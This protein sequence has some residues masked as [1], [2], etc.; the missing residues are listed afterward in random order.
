MNLQLAR[1]MVSLIDDK[2]GLDIML[3]NVGKATTLADYFI[4]ATGTSS[5]H[6]QALADHLEKSLRDENHFMKHKE[7]KATNGWLL[8][9]FKDIVVHLFNSETRAYY[10]L[11][12]IWSDAEIMTI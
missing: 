10:A 5:T 2:K 11:E 1:R 12:R 4:I 8:L 9:D 6:I 3:L 7:G